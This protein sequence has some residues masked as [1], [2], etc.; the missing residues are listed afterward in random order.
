MIKSNSRYRYID[1]NIYGVIL[2]VPFYEKTTTFIGTLSE[3]RKKSSLRVKGTENLFFVND[4]P[5][6]DGFLAVP[7]S[8][9]K[10]EIKISPFQ[11]FTE[12]GL[13]ELNTEI[14][15]LKDMFERER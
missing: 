1:D 15:K 14:A 11:S 12:T 6:V 5:V 10:I 8:D 3:Y 2:K 13:S 9:F 7:L 4:T